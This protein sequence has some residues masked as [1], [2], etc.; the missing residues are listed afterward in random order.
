MAGIVPHFQGKN[1]TFRKKERE[2]SHAI[3]HNYS[4]EKLALVAEELRQAKLKSIKAKLDQKYGGP[5]HKITI[6]MM[7]NTNKGAKKWV[8]LST[9]EIIEI[10]RRRK[11]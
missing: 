7:A 1:R 4:G 10:Y 8:S 5:S 11:T 2:L 9:G 3:K 6:D